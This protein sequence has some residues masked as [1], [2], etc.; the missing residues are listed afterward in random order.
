M[1]YIDSST[2]AQ[3]ER[4]ADT[5]EETR[6]ETRAERRQRRAQISRAVPQRAEAERA[7][8]RQEAEAKAEQKTG[9]VSWGKWKRKVSRNW[10]EGALY[11]ERVSAR[12]N[13]HHAHAAEGAHLAPLTPFTRAAHARTC[14]GASMHN[15]AYAAHRKR[16]AHTECAT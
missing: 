10:L 13:D 15:T 11:K 12:G 16:A 14:I 7:T 3:D 9:K 2:V 8:A 4:K 5:R 1:S 6:E